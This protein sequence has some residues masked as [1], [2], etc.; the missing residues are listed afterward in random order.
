MQPILIDWNGITIGSYAALL[1]LG[2]IAAS[3]IVWLEA[4]RWHI[5][6]AIWLDAILAAISIGVVAARL[7]YAA[8]NWAYFKDHLDEVLRIWDGGL[9]W[10]AGLIGG[11][12]GAWL[13]AHRQKD[14]SPMQL[15]D[16]LALG[17][18][19]GIALGWIGCYLAAAA[20]GQ[21]MFPG[22][23]LYFLSIDAPDLY[24]SINPRW[25]AQLFGAA[26]AV[27]VFGLVL[28]T[29][30]KKWQDGVRFWLFIMLYSLGA[31][32]IGFIRADDMPII[33]GWRLDQ[34]FDGALGIIGGIAVFIRWGERLLAPGRRP[35]A[36]D[37]Q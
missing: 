25:P 22:Q 11:S 27:V 16:L 4:R 1:D 6:S 8:I 18:P 9:N 36:P 14:H 19:I 13:I 21:E 28:L 2:L 23:P 3:I 35:P 32:L 37:S 34:V 31:F 29:R 12:I 7:G 30:N 10:Q 33:S 17:A 5:R 20:Y 24:G 26:W 15:L